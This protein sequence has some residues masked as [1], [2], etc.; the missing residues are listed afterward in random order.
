MDQIAPPLC[1]RCWQPVLLRDE[2][3]RLG[4][5]TDVR[6]NGEPVYLWS[7]LHAYD[8]ASGGCA[9]ASSSAAA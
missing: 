3:I 2:F 4:H 5:I 8:V 7:Y 1:E 6:P 9:G